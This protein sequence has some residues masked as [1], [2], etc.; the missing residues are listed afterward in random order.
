MPVEVDSSALCAWH[1]QSITG[2]TVG[3]ACGVRRAHFSVLMKGNKG[4]DEPPGTF[5]HCVHLHRQTK[6]LFVRT[7]V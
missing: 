1:Q 3:G 6:V 4:G 2:D 5:T 7:L